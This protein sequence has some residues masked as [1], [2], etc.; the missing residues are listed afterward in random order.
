MCSQ[1]IMPLRRVVAICYPGAFSPQGYVQCMG[2]SEDPPRCK[3][4]RGVRPH[5]PPRIVYSKDSRMAGGDQLLVWCYIAAGMGFSY[6][7]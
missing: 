3:L 7:G 1:Q 2:E 6:P 5:F 4:C